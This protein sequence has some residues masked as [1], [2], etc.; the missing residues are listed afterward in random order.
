MFFIH[1]NILVA[2]GVAKT[3]DSAILFWVRLVPLGLPLAGQLT[4]PSL[5]RE[6][7]TVGIPPTLHLIVGVPQAQPLR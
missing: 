5:S 7:F 2:R 3:L 6:S 1:L 4:Q